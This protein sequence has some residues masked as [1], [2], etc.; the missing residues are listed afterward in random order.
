SFPVLLVSQAHREGLLGGADLLRLWPMVRK[1][2]EYI[3]CN[4]PVTQQDR[5]E[6]DPGY[7]PFT[8]AIE[9]AALLAGAD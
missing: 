4:G 9:V 2:L 7:S 3:A 8:L 5:W 6:E 1:A